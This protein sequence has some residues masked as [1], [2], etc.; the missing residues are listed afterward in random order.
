MIVFRWT[1]KRD[2]HMLTNIH[3]LPISANDSASN[4]KPEIIQDYNKHMG[5]WI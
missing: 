2:I 3:K 4:N 1:D 5:M